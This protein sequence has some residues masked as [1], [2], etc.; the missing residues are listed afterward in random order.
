MQEQVELMWLPLVQP[1]PKNVSINSGNLLSLW[2]SDF[3]R[4]CMRSA[5][6][7]VDLGAINLVPTH[8]VDLGQIRSS[9][10]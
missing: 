1:T 6:Q 9:N 5:Q 4:R 7:T 2:K 10:Q 8:R 3:L